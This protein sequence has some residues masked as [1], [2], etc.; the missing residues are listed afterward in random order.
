M[1]ATQIPSH[2]GPREHVDDQRFRELGCSRCRY[3]ISG[4][5]RCRNPKFRPRG[6]A[7]AS[8]MRLLVA[9]QRTEHRK[10]QKAGHRM[11]RQQ[12]AADA[13]NKARQS[14]IRRLRDQLKT[15]ERE[16]GQGQEEQ[17]KRRAELSTVTISPAAHPAAPPPRKY[18]KTLEPHVPS[19]SEKS[20][21]HAK[22][23]DMMDMSSPSEEA[24]DPQS[25]PV[26]VREEVTESKRS[27]L[28]KLSDNVVSRREKRRLSESPLASTPKRRRMASETKA[29]SSCAKLNKQGQ[30]EVL[31][32]S[33]PRQVLWEPPVS[34]YGLLEEELYADPWKLL[35]ACMLLN[36]TS[37]TQV[38]KVIWDLFNLCPT[39]AKAISVDTAEIQAIIQPLGL[40]RKRALAIQ[41]LS[42]DYLYKEWNNPV[43][44]YGIGKYAS[45]AYHIFCRGH[46]KSIDPEDK[47]LRR[48][49]DWLRT[50][51][52]LG[53]GLMRYQQAVHSS[54]A[55]GVNE[56]KL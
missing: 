52:G 55:N 29:S 25:Q 47:D 19:Q 30:V 26:L 53:T 40:F 8:E 36:K 34:P 37:A 54:T 9:A 31:P 17:R 33:D 38:R 28:E 10:T 3:S 21:A 41:R 46:W 44:L 12:E 2:E 18:R 11:Q 20:S 27:F 35:V 49:T 6:I 16:A 22:D 24:N 42:E 56:D 45:D 7:S 48:Y 4:C 39:P 50:T 15:S 51:G 1:G 13:G 43:E 5:S 32:Q 14:L 23:E